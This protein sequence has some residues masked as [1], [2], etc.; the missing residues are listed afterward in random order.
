MELDWFDIAAESDIPV[1]GMKAVDVAGRRILVCRLREGLY[2]VDAICTHAAAS[3]EEGWL[4]GHRLTCPLHGA[5]F[6]VRDGRVLSPPAFH[7]LPTH[8]VRVEQGR[9]LVAIGRA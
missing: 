2:A 8:R 4:R 6:D 1:G 7:W 3:L 9:I 5:A